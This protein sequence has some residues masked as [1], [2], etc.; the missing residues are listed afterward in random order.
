MIPQVLGIPVSSRAKAT[1]FGRAKPPQQGGLE[2]EVK[3]AG[4]VILNV[5]EGSG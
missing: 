2:R 4:G 1:A 5:P 3:S